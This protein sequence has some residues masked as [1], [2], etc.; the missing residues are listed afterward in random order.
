MKIKF[1]GVYTRPIEIED[2][3]NKDGLYDIKLKANDFVDL[4]SDP[5]FYMIYSD[6]E[7]NSILAIK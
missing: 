3:E 1:R 7:F 5:D 4:I 6:G 2:V